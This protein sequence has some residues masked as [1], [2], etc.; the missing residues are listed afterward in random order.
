[1]T[2]PNGLF[3]TLEGIEGV[4]KTTHLAHIKSRCEETGAP[5]V[6]TREPGGT[7]ISEAIRY[8]LLDP[9]HKGAM[10]PMAELL[11]VFA[12]RAQHIDE[13]IRPA[14][15][16]GQIVICDRFTDSTYAY[17]G[18][19]RRVPMEHIAMLEQL[20]QGSLRPHLTLMFDAPLDVARKR[21]KLRSDPD[22]FESEADDYFKAVRASFLEQ[23]K[24]AP[25]RIKVIDASQDVQQV[26]AQLDAVL[27]D[28]LRQ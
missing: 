3:V 11:L 10:R 15:D 4:G 28:F 18:G 14:L 27:D 2:A 13:L 24:A 7:A 9:A 8:L 16:K 26:S 20:V 23:A 25:D 6:C 22:R 21:A 17:Q 12:A 19:G 1:M 5:V